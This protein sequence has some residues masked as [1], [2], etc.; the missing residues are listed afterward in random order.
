MVFEMREPALCV[1]AEFDAV[2]RATAPEIQH[3]IERL[4]EL[5]RLAGRDARVEDGLTE[6]SRVSKGGADDAIMLGL[7]RDDLLE[8]DD[9]RATRSGRAL[10]TFLFI[11]A[12]ARLRIDIEEHAIVLELIGAAAKQ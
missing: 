6:A 4:F 2:G 11:G 12:V 1:A 3:P 5:D 8:G 10:A 7:V 9:L